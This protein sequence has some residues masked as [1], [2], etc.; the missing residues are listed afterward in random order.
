MLR[1]QS[2]FNSSAPSC[3]IAVAVRRTDPSRASAWTTTVPETGEL[4]LLFV[5]ACRAGIRSTYFYHLFRSN[6]FFEAD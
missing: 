4:N 1:L 5:G 3:R 2:G 6:W